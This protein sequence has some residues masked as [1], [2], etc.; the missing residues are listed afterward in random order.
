MRGPRRD[1][2]VGLT[3]SDAIDAE[4]MAKMSD[5]NVLGHVQAEDTPEHAQS[6]K[7]K[8]E[9]DAGDEA[10]HTCNRNL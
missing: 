2:A 7:P 6:E 3:G 8:I 5:H 1:D 10:K 9:R 4:D